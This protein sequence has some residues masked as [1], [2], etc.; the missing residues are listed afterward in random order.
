MRIDESTRESH[1]LDLHHCSEIADILG[2]ARPEPNLQIADSQRPDNRLLR[3]LNRTGHDISKRVCNPRQVGD[4][5]TRIE[6]DIDERHTT[7]ACRSRPPA[8]HESIRQLCAAGAPAQYLGVMHWSP[9]RARGVEGIGGVSGM[10]AETR[11][12]FEDLGRCQQLR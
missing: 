1:R 8:Q 2:P 7:Y 4:V 3:T 9:V 5:Q 10:T 6:E 11:Q 12:L